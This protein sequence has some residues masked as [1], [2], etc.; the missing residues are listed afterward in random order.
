MDRTARLKKS[1]VKPCSRLV[2]ATMRSFKVFT[3][4]KQLPFGSDDFTGYQ[5]QLVDVVS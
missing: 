5:Q 3:C 1:C 4:T 2:A